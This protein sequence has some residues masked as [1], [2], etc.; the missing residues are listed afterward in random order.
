MQNKI[1][2]A[3]LLYTVAVF[4]AMGGLQVVGAG[5][6]AVQLQATKNAT[7]KCRLNDYGEFIDCK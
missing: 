1:C 5:A 6:M 2:I 3:M 7:Y 4:I